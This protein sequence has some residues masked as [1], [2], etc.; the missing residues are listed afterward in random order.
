VVQTL[1]CSA[2]CLQHPWPVPT[3][4]STPL[5]FPLWQQKMSEDSANIPW[6]TKL[7]PTEYYSGHWTT[8]VTLYLQPTSPPWGGTWCPLYH[9]CRSSCCWTVPCIPFML[10]LYIKILTESLRL[11]NLL[12]C[13]STIQKQIN[14]STWYQ[15]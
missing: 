7:P 5:P 2:G 14:M 1:L 10:L 15:S 3:D 6:G 8:W 12:L 4:D 13:L 9:H 11:G